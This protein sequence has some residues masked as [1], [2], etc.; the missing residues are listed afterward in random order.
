MKSSTDDVDDD[1]IKATQWTHAKARTKVYVEK[2]VDQKDL[3]ILFLKLPATDKK[4]T[5]YGKS[6]RDKASVLAFELKQF[7][8]AN[9]NFEDVVKNIKKLVTTKN[10]IHVLLYLFIIE[11]FVRQHGI[12][13]ISGIPFSIGNGRQRFSH[14]LFYDALPHYTATIEKDD[15]GKYLPVVVGIDNC[16][17]ILRTFNGS[18]KVSAELFQ[19][20]K[21]LYKA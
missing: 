20:M 9:K 10:A 21:K 12:C 3:M 6:L 7:R 4:N 1:F 8:D 14:A 5:F 17:L 16:Q 13:A 19:H 15:D 18:S 11:L 2:L